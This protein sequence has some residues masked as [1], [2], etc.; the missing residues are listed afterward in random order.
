VTTVSIDSFAAPWNPDP[1]GL[2]TLTSTP[3]A[4]FV[5]VTGMQIVSSSGL[6]ADPAPFAQRQFPTALDL[7]A[8]DELRFWFR[9]SRSG[10]GSPTRPLYLILR[11]MSPLPA[12]RLGAACSPS[13][14]RK[15]GTCTACGWP[16]CLPPCGRQWG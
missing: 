5:G 7:R 4:G 8:Y 3:D 10:D 9:S 12:V 2:W 11:P 16:I 1:G 6:A 14:N 15:P 13:T